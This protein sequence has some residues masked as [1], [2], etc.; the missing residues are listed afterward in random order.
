MCFFFRG[1]GFLSSPKKHKSLGLFYPSCMSYR[2][3]TRIEENN[4]LAF[5]SEV[6]RQ[7]RDIRN[8]YPAIETNVKWQYCPACSCS[9]FYC[10]LK[11]PKTFKKTT[12]SFYNNFNYLALSF[13][14]K[15]R[16]KGAT[17]SF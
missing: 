17:F 2:S 10:T 12:Y 5:F 9:F 4:R 13:F 15:T 16:G 14:C 8:L 6:M 1:R 3:K 11:I 7:E